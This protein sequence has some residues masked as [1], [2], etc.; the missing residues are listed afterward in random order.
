[1][2]STSEARK[3]GKGLKCENWEIWKNHLESVQYKR[4]L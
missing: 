3:L 1:M 4:V 2:Y